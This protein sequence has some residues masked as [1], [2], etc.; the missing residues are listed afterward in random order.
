M[1]P[2]GETAWEPLARDLSAQFTCLVFAMEVYDG[3]YFYYEL[4]E[5]GRL[6]DEY[7]SDP[8]PFGYGEYSGRQPLPDH[9]LLSR[10]VAEHAVI[11]CRAF[12]NDTALHDIARILADS[13]NESS[14]YHGDAA[15]QFRAIIDAL[16]LPKIAGIGGAAG[17]LQ[18][19]APFYPNFTPT[20]WR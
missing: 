3:D 13:G 6:V 12:H 9:E 4:Y 19:N 20:R 16:D 14:P 10:S 7:V 11:L 5:T 2:R 17:V 18:A 15:K 8:D 1:Y